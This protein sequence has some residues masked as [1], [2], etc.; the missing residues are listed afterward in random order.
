M[1]I[2]RLISR[3]ALLGVLVCS[4]SVLLSQQKQRFASLDEALA[5]GSALSGRNGPR[6]LNW[7]DGGNRFSFIDRDPRTNHDVIRTYDPVSGRDTVLFTGEGLKFPGTQQ[8]F[9]Y[10]EFQW[11]QDSKH[12]V[13]QSNF[14]QIYRRSGVS[15]FYIYSVADHS[16]QLATRGARTGELSPNGARLGYEKGGNMYVTDLSTHQE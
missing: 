6:S 12:L 1:R 16:L 14:Q 13:F 2:I 3:R 11:A 8:E 9:S 7:I 15:D 4:P 5:A 10:D